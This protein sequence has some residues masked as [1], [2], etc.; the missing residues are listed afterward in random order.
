MFHIVRRVV[1]GLALLVPVGLC[2]AQDLAREQTILLRVQVDAAGKVQSAQPLPDPNAVEALNRVA[3]DLARKLPFA[4]AKKDGAA[5]AS[6]TT[7]YLK[8]AMEPKAGGQ[9]GIRLAQASNGP[10]VVQMGRLHLPEN[11]GLRGPVRVVVNVPLRA[12]GAPDVDGIKT[13]KVEMKEASSFAEARYMAAIVA[14]LRESRFELDKVG[15]AAVP[16]RASLPYQFGGGGRGRRGGGEK[17]DKEA[18]S[19]SSSVL[20]VTGVSEQAGV[21][22]PKVIFV[23][24]VTAKKEG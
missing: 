23:A 14:S 21:E 6:E 12:D 10:H 13:E 3:V 2:A 24:P 16:T 4:P 8:L 7:L 17:A 22:L 20:G 15:G 1:C 5:V 18:N 11:K 19:G 9:F